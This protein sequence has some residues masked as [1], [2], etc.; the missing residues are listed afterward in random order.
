[1]SRDGY[2]VDM[3][4][5]DLRG[6]NPSEESQKKM[7]KC[8][9]ALGALRKLIELS[10]LNEFPVSPLDE[11]QAK[12]AEAG[13]SVGEV[14][15]RKYRIDIREDGT[16]KIAPIEKGKAD[17]NQTINDFNAG[18]KDVQVLF[19]NEAMSTGFSLHASKT[20]KDQRD[21]VSI[22]AQAYDNTVTFMQALGRTNRAG[23]VEGARPQFKILHTDHP[24]EMRYVAQLVRKVQSLN[25]N[26][27]ASGASQIDL[28]ATPNLFNP[29]GDQAVLDALNANPEL[30][31]LPSEKDADGRAKPLPTI[32]PKDFAKKVI[33]QLILVDPAKA[34]AVSAELDLAYNASVDLLL[35][36]GQNADQARMM[37]VQAVSVGSTEIKPP[38]DKTKAETDVFQD[39]VRL[40]RER[41]LRTAPLVTPLSLTARVAQSEREDGGTILRDDAEFHQERVDRFEQEV[42]DLKK[43]YDAH[44]SSATEDKAQLT[45]AEKAAAAEKK[46]KSPDEKKL[47]QLTC[48]VAKAESALRQSQQLA[49]E[50][51]ERYEARLP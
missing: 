25:A 37:D 38:V 30:V 14:T 27:T 32:A 28:A 3:D 7:S 9:R 19:G 2:Y 36:T 8:S 49:S 29:I 48:A 51:K 43:I 18:S 44:E 31:I 47:A 50:A 45:K 13:L 22:F 4:S 12:L 46:K 35:D 5:I 15:G 20:F 1:M 17:K 41:M 6:V 23:S 11:M 24:T 42:N 26:T 39:G 21:R 34:R 40:Q 16:R 10:D 33:Q